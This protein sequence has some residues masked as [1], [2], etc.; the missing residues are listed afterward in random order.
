MTVRRLKK[1]ET[2]GEIV[3]A[4]GGC[5]P[6]ASSYDRYRVTP[7]GL[8]HAWTAAGINIGG[9]DRRAWIYG[10]ALQEYVRE[11]QIRS[12]NSLRADP[13]VGPHY[14]W[15]A[16]KLDESGDCGYFFSSYEEPIET[17]LG[18]LNALPAGI[19]LRHVLEILRAAGFDV[20]VPERRPKT[21]TRSKALSR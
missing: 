14:D 17:H 13:F 11:R 12:E 20:P 9:D 19:T 21:K 10:N 1:M 6:I 4:L 7:S 8:R 3:R 15:I 2:V 5:N 18:C 16:A